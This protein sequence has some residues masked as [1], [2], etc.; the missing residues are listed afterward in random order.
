MSAQPAPGTPGATDGTAVTPQ[1]VRVPDWG[2]QVSLFQTR[3]PAF[4]LYVAVLGICALLLA[5]QQLEY[6]RYSPIA[7][8]FGFVLLALFTVPI[9]ILI[10]VLD[11]FER[12]PLSLMVGAFLWG[13][14]AVLPLALATNNALVELW[15]KLFG[16]SIGIGW[17]VAIVPPPVEEILKFI[18]I[19]L[20]FLIASNEF[21][22][23]LDGFVY[24]ALVGLGFQV[25]EDMF[26]FFTRFIGPAQGVNEIGAL[27]EG[28][29]IRV[30]S[31]GLYSHPLY[32]SLSG[33]GI[34]Y[35]ATRTDKPVSRRRLFLWGGLLLAIALHVF[36][37]APL[38]NGLL[39]DHPGPVNWLVFSAIKG[40]PLLIFIGVIVGLATRREQTYFRAITSPQVAA[41]VVQPD[42]LRTLSSLRS[43]FAARRAMRAR[44]GPIA[45]GL[46]ARIQR[47]QL[48]YAMLSTQSIQ[49]RESVLAGQSELIRSLRAELTA[50]PDLPHAVVAT[51]AV[52]AQPTV[53]VATATQVAPVAPAAPTGWM[54]THRAAPPGQQ[55]WDQPDPSR[56]MTPLAGYLD[57]MVVQRVGD[58]ARVVASNGWSGWVDARLLIPIQR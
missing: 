42:E 3:Q 7:F 32:A 18:G 43:R 17:I 30:I 38:L 12:E 5:G 36:W 44:K 41:D 33:M 8:V 25:A 57:L 37:N 20:I 46:L 16:A 51:R 34:A 50:M 2:N 14:V 35:W 6:L 29:W 58:W 4:W 26:Y 10:G 23:V 49:N 55:S 47:E 31:G 53:A 54:P 45:A 52:A 39:G 15:I 56:P 48:R 21:D 1:T 22:D 9:F 27:I 13:A 11:L 28:Y 19:M 24:G 40:I